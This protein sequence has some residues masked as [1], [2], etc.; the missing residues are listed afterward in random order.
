M[1]S[2]GCCLFQD[3]CA[4]QVWPGLA[5]AKGQDGGEHLLES[6]SGD[7]GH[8]SCTQQGSGWGKDQFLP[9]MEPVSLSVSS[10]VP[11]GALSS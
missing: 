1:G 10:S 9:R 4:G 11:F 3:L 5:L 2:V 7:I 6:S 8:L